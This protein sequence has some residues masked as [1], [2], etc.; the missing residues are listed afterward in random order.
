MATAAIGV[1]THKDT[2]AAC[3]V[4]GLGIARDEQAFHND[5]AGHAAFAAW[6]R[7]QEAPVRV[8]IEGSASSGCAPGAR[9]AAARRRSGRGGAAGRRRRG[10]P[11][12]GAGLP[13]RRSP[14][15]RRT[16]CASRHRAS[17]GGEPGR[18]VRRSVVCR[19]PMSRCSGS[20]RLS[21]LVIE[22]R[23]AHGGYE[24]GTAGNELPSRSVRV[25]TGR[26]NA[27]VTGTS[28]FAWQ[29]AL[30][31]TIRTMSA[32]VTAL[33][34]SSTI[35]ASILEPGAWPPAQARSRASSDMV[36]APGSNAC[37]G[38]IR[39]VANPTDSGR[40]TAR[41]QWP[42]SRNCQSAPAA[43]VTVANPQLSPRGATK[44]TEA[45]IA[46]AVRHPCAG[47]PSSV[48]AS[49]PRYARRAEAGALSPSSA[50][51]GSLSTAVGNATSV[52]VQAS[53]PIRLCGSPLAA[54]VALA[55]PVG[56]PD[57]DGSDGDGPP[58]TVLGVGRS[59]ATAAWL[60]AGALDGCVEVPPH[61]RIVIAQITPPARRPAA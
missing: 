45:A 28:G 12:A 50:S 10:A 6:V 61:P 30:P 25:P 7:E 15:E 59:E 1:D 18:W 9:P 17:A 34:V 54:G 4:D 49:V 55:P 33:S 8:G 37:A 5:P 47:S 16:A 24:R 42:P 56:A 36:A 60:L 41:S 43:D 27:T 26:D 31:T 11:T 53:V 57:A 13:R 32:I 44:V 29:S 48:A 39:Q 23:L 21:R 22:R 19:Q 2:L 35:G 58:G 51:G 38:S 46:I 14:D 40:R 3:L 20:H 52:P